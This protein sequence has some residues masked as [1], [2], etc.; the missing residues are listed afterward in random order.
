MPKVICLHADNA[1][2]EAIDRTHSYEALIA[3]NHIT[4]AILARNLRLSITGEQ[5]KPL[6]G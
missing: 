3:I 4:Q 2:M 5:D 6:R 1:H